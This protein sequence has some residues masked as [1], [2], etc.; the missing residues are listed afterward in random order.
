MP[1]YQYNCSGC[2]QQVELFFRSVSAASKP[3]CPECGSKKL[4]RRMSRV[5]RVRSESQRLADIDIDQELGKLDGKS[6]ADFA[7][8]TRRMGDELGDEL[9]ADFRDLADRTD[10]G[11]DP[12]ERA[13]PAFTL[14]NRV[15]R[16][17]EQLAGDSGD[18]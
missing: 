17:K 4:K 12:V 18:E 15:E 7:R 5:A 6:E 13:D 11:A 10:A 16:R 8:W 1:I 2:H 14:R 3:T 9:G